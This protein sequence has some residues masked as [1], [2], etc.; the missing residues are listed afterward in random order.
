M[1][2][3]ISQQLGNYRIIRLLGHGG[4][5]DVYLG[6]HVYLKTTA[7]IKV[8]HTRLAS[9]DIEQFR[10]EALTI[11]HLTHPHIVRVL[12]FAVESFV[13]FLIMEYAPYGNLR[14]RHPTGT[15]VPPTTFLAYVQQIASALQ[16]AHDRR[17]VHRDVKP[18]N[19]LIGRD[20][21]ILLSDFGTAL[22]AQSSLSQSTEDTV[23]G[24]LSYMAPE[25]ILGKPRPA[26]DQYALAVVVYE[27]L[28]GTKP[29]K[30]SYM[31]IVTQH[32]SATPPPLDQTVQAFPPIVQQVLQQAL[33]KD[34]HQRFP[35]VQNFADALAQAF[36]GQQPV[37][38]QPPVPETQSPVAATPSFQPLSLHKSVPVRKIAHGL[39]R[40]VIILLI[41]VLL[42]GL[43]LCG[44][45]FAAFR[46]FTTQ[47]PA[48][49]AA[50]AGARAVANNFVQAVST[51]YYDQ[52]YN[53]LG[54]PV[55]SQTTRAQFGQQGQSEDQCYGD[56][57]DY[58]SI[59][60]ASQGKTASYSYA[61]SRARLQKPYQL[62]LTL[63]Q[64]SSGNW[65]VT[66]YNSNITSVQPTCT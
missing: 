62:Q 61:L 44:L 27:W 13:P 18:E 39:R 20:N 59:G 19:M 50:S 11:A 42:A 9:E 21:E 36:Q 45:G 65:Q 52:A 48:S 3:Q 49:S 12:D 17:L 2:E 43:L 10:T 46:H 23:I 30:G 14:E 47:S 66:D 54:P 32:L 53:D 41:I 4:F 24:T 51:R 63:Q 26:S 1:A 5:A 34:P 22:A 7:A 60:T 58:S 57:T 16:Y 31:E 40:G 35:S 15:L 37:L 64:N 55:T 38:L 8:L 29:F 6:E 25:Q 56:V 28:S 33:A